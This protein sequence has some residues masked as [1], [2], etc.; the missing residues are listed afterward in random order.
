MTVAFWVQLLLDRRS[1]I[2]ESTHEIAAQSRAVLE[3][4]L[5]QHLDMLRGLRDLWDGLPLEP[6]G[7][8]EADV[9]RRVD[10]VPGLVSLAL[11]D[12][13]SRR[14]ILAGGEWSGS[15]AIALDDVPADL[16]AARLVGPESDGGGRVGYRVLLPVTTLRGRHGTVVARF[17]IRPF[18]AGVLRGRLRGYALSVFWNDAEVFTRGVP[19][20]GLERHWWRVEET[21]QLP[22]G[23]TWRVHLQPTAELASTRL[24]AVPHYLLVLGLLLS[25]VLAVTVYQ[26]ILISRQSSSLAR[27]NRALAERGL[28]LESKV[29]DRTEALQEAIEELEAFNYSVSHDLRSPL[30]AILNFVT[31]LEEEYRDRPLDAAGATML[32][33]IRRS[34]TR[35]NDLLEDLLHLSRAGRSALSPE[36]IDMTEMARETFAQ[37]CASDHGGE[38]AWEVEPLPDAVGDRALLSDVFANL[39]GNAIKYSRGCADPRVRVRGRVEGDE[40]IYEVI[41]NGR[42][43]DMRFA[44]KLFGLF[45]RIDATESVEGT[46]VGLA[47]VARIIKRH[48]GRVW[49]EG[50]PGAGARFS[51][52]IPRRKT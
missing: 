23:G 28:E 11:I 19:S 45:E 15:N 48:S 52:S 30:G 17:E 2:L 43:F 22:L 31:I 36:P 39:F 21:I 26:F 46:G 20:E 4:T 6:T 35:A 27:S 5:E 40:C 34:A 42:G 29:A 18:L 41:D 16:E 33:R 9:D 50:R 37:V 13:D 14:T 44:D 51:F 3:S 49:A 38:V 1:Q 47:I 12:L 7:E 10:R 24:T 8:W 25:I 32:R